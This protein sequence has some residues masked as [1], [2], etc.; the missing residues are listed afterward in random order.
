M[1]IVLDT[2]VLI[3]A[4]ISHGGC[5]EIL[6][7]CAL[8][9][10]ITL[11]QFILA[12]L[13]EKLTGKFGFSGSEVNNV[14][15]LLKSQCTIVQPEDLPSPISRDPDDDSIIAAA[16]AGLCDCIITGDKDLLVLEQVF[17]ID[18][19]PPSRFWKYEA[20]LE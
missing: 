20:T 13:K 11:S 3:A 19:I 1:K 15:R 2:N 17:G 8:I 6:E 9:H 4:F 14:V 10:E 5:N 16:I 7:H 12:E 18:I